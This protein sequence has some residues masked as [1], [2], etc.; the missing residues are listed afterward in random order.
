MRLRQRIAVREGQSSL[1]CAAEHFDFRELARR[2]LP[3]SVFEY[4]AGGADAETTLR[5]NEAAFERVSFSA[6]VLVDVER[7]DLTTTVCGVP[8]ALPVLIA[9]TGLS[10]VVHPGG[11]LAGAKAAK[12]RGTVLI[13][14]TGASYSIEEVAVGI[15]D[16]PWFQLY[17][18]SGRVSMGNLLDRANQTCCPVLV[19]TVDSPVPG[20]RIRDARNGM[21][22]PPQLS[23]GNVIDGLRHPRWLAGLLTRRRVTMQN[24]N[25]AKS[26]SA[27]SIAKDGMKLLN[28]SF[29]WKDLEDIRNRWPRKL[30]VKGVMS[31]ADATR[32]VDMGADG[33]VVSNHGGR[34]LDGGVASLDA[35]QRVVQA[36]GDSA[37]VMIDG[38]VRR[39]SDV[40]KAMALGA[41]VC[42]IG[43]PWLY[44]LAAG[45]QDGVVEVLD[46]LRAELDRTLALLGRS[47]VADLD[48]SCLWA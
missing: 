15:G 1:G 37:D 9:P 31:A 19:V 13:L 42:L 43:R 44:G 40:A 39:G 28:P 17:P 32:A 4:V 18:S 45:G 21:T 29:N 33:V 30:I 12:S 47:A 3:K 46:V 26:G 6:S 25:V 8:L 22:I 41:K 38:G 5:Q 24:I 34:Q 27:W 48:V 11:E 10:G 14:S 16:P 23:V 7:R 36:I 2:R 35:L 20:N